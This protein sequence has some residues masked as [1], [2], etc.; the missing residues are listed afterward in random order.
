M[1]EKESFITLTQVEVSHL[2]E[3]SVKVQTIMILSLR[4]RPAACIIKLIT[5]LMYGFCNKLEGLSLNTRLGWKGLPGANTLVYYE[6]RKKF[7][8]IGPGANSINHFS[9]LG[10][11]SL[12]LP[13]I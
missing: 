2:A 4:A 5:V 8:D 7:N 1:T 13:N 9:K 6:N 11:F 3:Q 10:R 12:D